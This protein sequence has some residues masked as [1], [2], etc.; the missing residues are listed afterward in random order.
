MKRKIC[1]PVNLDEKIFPL[2][3]VLM[4]K[5]FFSNQYVLA[6]VLTLLKFNIEVIQSILW[7]GKTF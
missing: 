7:L 3:E 2:V 4:C 1:P 6:F 5:F